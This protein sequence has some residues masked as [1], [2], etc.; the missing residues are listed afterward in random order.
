MHSFSHIRFFSTLS[1]FF[2]SIA[3]AVI[4]T[5]ANERRLKY[6]YLEIYSDTRILDKLTVYLLTLYKLVLARLGYTT[7]NRKEGR[8]MIEKK[9]AQHVPTLTIDR[10][11]STGR[12]T[13]TM[14]VDRHSVSIR[15]S[16]IVYYRIFLAFANR[17]A[18]QF[19]ST[20]I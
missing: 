14:I 20:S 13:S 15:K 10:D 12:P 11:S 6:T 19:Q 4:T 18:A 1:F 9:N 2:L 3:C 16:T 7:Y 17:A 8:K 5:W